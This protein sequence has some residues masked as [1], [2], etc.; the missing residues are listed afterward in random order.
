M[1]IQEINLGTGPNTG[2]GDPIRG[3]FGKVNDNFTEVGNNLVNI[4]YN[5]T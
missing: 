1:A 5:L 3:A 4:E 2:T